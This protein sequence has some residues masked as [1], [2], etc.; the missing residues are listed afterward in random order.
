MKIYIQHFEGNPTGLSEID[1]LQEKLLYQ[2]FLKQKYRTMWAL[3]SLENEINAEGGA[4]I[5]IAET[6]QLNFKSFSKD[7]IDKM[8][9]LLDEQDKIID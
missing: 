5:I 6:G 3:R 4:I 7:L 9:F 8:L 1:I 2:S